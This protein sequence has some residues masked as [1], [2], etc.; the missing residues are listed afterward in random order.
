MINKVL[1]YDFKGVILFIGSISL[2]NVNDLLTS[3]GLLLNCSYLGYQ[4]YKYHKKNKND[5]F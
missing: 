4:F 5:R 2:T 1:M 3:V